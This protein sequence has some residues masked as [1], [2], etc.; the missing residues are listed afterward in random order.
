MA[1]SPF[2]LTCWRNGIEFSVK[3]QYI[4]KWFD[5]INFT[6]A[7]ISP[8]SAFSFWRWQTVSSPSPSGICPANWLHGKP[9]IRRPK[10]SNKKL[11]FIENWKLNQGF[12]SSSMKSES[13]TFVV[14]VFTQLCQFSVIIL[15]ESTLWG[16]VDDDNNITTVFFQWNIISERIFDCKVV[17]WCGLFVIDI[18]WLGHFFGWGGLEMENL[19][20]SIFQSHFSLSLSRFSINLF[21]IKMLKVET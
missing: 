19:F 15:C 7:K 18:T 5:K 20:L 3:N 4:G 6:L 17:N 8:K 11:F 21:I 12:Q 9:R 10:R 14:I 13:Q 2:T 16:D 1:E